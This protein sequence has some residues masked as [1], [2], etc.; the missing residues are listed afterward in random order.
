M[1]I[2]WLLLS[3]LLF[4]GIGLAKEESSS[5]SS[6]P[7]QASIIKGPSGMIF[8]KAIK[9][10]TQNAQAVHFVKEEPKGC[11]YLADYSYPFNP[12]HENMYNGLRDAVADINGNY[13]VIDHFAGSG[14]PT[15]LCGRIFSCPKGK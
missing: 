15:M 9:N 8:K 1:K 11:T 4:T 13:F 3:S 7:N 10:N 5:S 12:G 2:F 6:R 14:N